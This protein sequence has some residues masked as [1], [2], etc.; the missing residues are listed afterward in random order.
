MLELHERIDF[1]WALVGGQLV[2]LHCAERGVAP[3]RPTN[4]VDTVVNIRAS[5]TMLKTF[6]GALKDMGFTPAT[7]GDGIQ[8]RWLRDH[9][10][11]DVLVPEGVGERAA[12]R[13][14]T[15]VQA[16][17]MRY[18]PDAAMRR[19]NMLAHTTASS[20]VGKTSRPSAASA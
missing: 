2:H 1:G 7:S 16:H 19:M 13:A 17:P 8:H 11:M 4:D 20:T 15:A 10:Q 18:L 3:I 6:T 9:A 5:P 12:T 14:W